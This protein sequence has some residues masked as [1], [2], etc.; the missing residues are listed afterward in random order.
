ML[1]LEETIGY[2]PFSQLYNA[3]KKEHDP[4]KEI[5]DPKE[6]LVISLARISAQAIGRY[7]SIIQQSL[8]PVK[9]DALAQFC[10]IYGCTIV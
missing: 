8:E 4:V 7:L 3:G 5:K 6:F 1:D 10:S 2:A 9:Q